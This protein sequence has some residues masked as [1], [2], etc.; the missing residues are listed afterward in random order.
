MGYMNK[1]MIHFSHKIYA[2]DLHVITKRSV[3]QK[4]LL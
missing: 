1:N 3:I 4:I 2:P